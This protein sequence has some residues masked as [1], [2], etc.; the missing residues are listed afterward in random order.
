MDCR[1][2]NRL[3]CRGDNR[4]YDIIVD[5]G[6][7]TII[8]IVVIFA[9]I[10]CHAQN[11]PAPKSLERRMNS[12]VI[13]VLM[14]LEDV[15]EITSRQDGR[16]FM[17]YFEKKDSPVFC[18][19]FSSKDFLHQIPVGKYIESFYTSDDK[20]VFNA[21]SFEFRD[22]KKTGWSYNDMKWTCHVSMQK[23]LNYFDDNFIFYPV[24]GQNPYNKS[25]ELEILVTFNESCT[26]CRISE[27]RCSNKSDFNEIDDTYYIIQKNEDPAD[28]KRDEEIFVGG[29]S[30]R[31]NDFGQGYAP[32]EPFTFFD[33]DVKIS[34]ITI[35]RTERYDYIRFKYKPRPFRIRLRNE[36]APMY[37][38]SFSG[39]EN[40]AIS[41]SAYN[42]GLDFGYSCPVSKGVRFGFHTGLGVTLSKIN[43]GSSSPV[44]Y[45]YDL[46]N[47]YGNYRRSYSISNI[48]QGAK[49]LDLTVPI[50]YTTEFKLHKAVSIL[51]DLGIKAYFN[52]NAM[53]TP[54]HIEGTVSGTYENGQTLQT[55]IDG[56]GDISGDYN[57]FV[58]LVT[59]KREPF[60]V[61]CI[62][63]IGLDINLYDSTVYLQAKAGYEYGLTYSYKSDEKPYFDPSNNVYPLVW[64]GR[65]NREIV[66]RP[67]ADCVSFK[68]QA[69]WV[70]LGIMIKL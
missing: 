8:L 3:D 28:A 25:F 54:F 69:L 36:Y 68:R 23:T 1:G 61:S 58:S 49:F 41:S 38:Y 46:S 24:L 60:D 15:S 18:D 17:N 21:F 35:D 44:S 12:M 64:D 33:D 32:K 31:Y 52:T 26:E 10:T 6:N 65:Y 47:E 20:S 4:L 48:S 30:V 67:L 5:M 43:L 53:T 66:F 39:D 19:L 57:E 11:A 63:N 29:E 37:A 40:L 45:S 62:G 14:G 51:V 56:V 22:I 34:T 16:E 50:Y 13:D 27:I 59:F 70:S 7:R 42:V 2:D 9:S 55:G